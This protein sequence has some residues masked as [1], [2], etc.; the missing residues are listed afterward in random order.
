MADCAQ[1]QA[2]L[3]PLTLGG[4]SCC[5]LLHHRADGWDKCPVA[6]LHIL[7]GR[8]RA[9]LD[10]PAS[11]AV[12][13]HTLLWDALDCLGGWGRRGCLLKK[14]SVEGSPDYRQIAI[15]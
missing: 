15:N 13:T 1:C 11:S 9:R 8:C 14:G 12:A 6:L 10:S 4:A 2:C 7:A 3:G 5:N